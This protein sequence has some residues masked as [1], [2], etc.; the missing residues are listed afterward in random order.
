[1]GVLGEGHSAGDGG[2]KAE[3]RRARD[4]GTSCSRFFFCIITL[5]QPFLFSLFLAELLGCDFER[6]KS[7][8]SGGRN[9]TPR[10]PSSPVCFHCS[11]QYSSDEVARYPPLFPPLGAI[12]LARPSTTPPPP[13][14]RRSG[15]RSYAL[16]RRESQCPP[17]PP[18]AVGF[19]SIYCFP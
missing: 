1:M 16:A 12:P 6:A 4:G 10:R 9:Q 2:W 19:N 18:T 7:Q 14:A 3:E 8:V 5:F 17:L 13:S 11:T 15:S